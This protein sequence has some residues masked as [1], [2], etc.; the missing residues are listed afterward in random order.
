LT[1]VPLISIVD[2]DDLF[3]TAVEKLVRSLGYTACTFASADEYLQSSLVK[4]TRCLIA[5]VQ[6]PNMNGLELQEQLA[7]LGLDTPIIFLTA[8]PDDALKARA[9]N[10]GAICFLQKPLDLQGRRLVD[11]LREALDR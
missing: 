8:Y 9:L 1:E 3:R 7:Q 2:D 4:T 6:M 10:G 11:C 5:D